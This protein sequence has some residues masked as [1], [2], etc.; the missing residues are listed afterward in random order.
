MVR[1][2]AKNPARPRTLRLW[3]FVLVAL[4]VMAGLVVV[5]ARARTEADDA[6][7]GQ[8]LVEHLRAGSQELSAMSSQAMLD[9]HD[10]PSGPS[11]LALSA[12]T[13]R[14]LSI[15]RDL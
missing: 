8:A 13:T 4:A 14:G 1:R 6:R 15:Y 7:R 9:S 2:H 10:D 11:L 5:A 12:V 3:P